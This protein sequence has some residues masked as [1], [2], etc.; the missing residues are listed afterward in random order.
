MLLLTLT[1]SSCC[2]SLES[3]LSA[4]LFDKWCEGSQNGVILTGL[5]ADGTRAREITRVNNEESRGAD[6][7]MH[8]TNCRIEVVSFAAH[9]DFTQNYEFIEK[10]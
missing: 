10:V 5:L 2:R 7:R 1:A 4:R 6:G 9:V 8:R 3:G